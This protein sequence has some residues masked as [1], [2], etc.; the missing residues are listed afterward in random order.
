MPFL[1]SEVPLYISIQ[2]VIKDVLLSVALWC[3]QT[4]SDVHIVVIMYKGTSLA[5]KRHPL[6]LYPTLGLCLGTCGA[7]RG[8]G[9]FLGAKK[10]C[11]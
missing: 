1:I 9:G 6:G 8:T 5:K 10:L 4:V 7:S 11:T 2:A 3:V